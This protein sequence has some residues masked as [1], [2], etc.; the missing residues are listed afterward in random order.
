MY[1]RECWPFLFTQLISENLPR[2]QHNSSSAPISACWTHYQAHCNCILVNHQC[3]A[4]NIPAEPARKRS[5]PHWAAVTDHTSN[6]PWLSPEVGTMVKSCLLAHPQGSIALGLSCACQSFA[7]AG[8][9]KSCNKIK[10]VWRFLFSH[11][12]LAQK[13]KLSSH[14]ILSF[15]GIKS[16]WKLSWHNQTITKIE[17]KA[18]HM[19]NAKNYPVG[20]LHEKN[21]HWTTCRPGQPLDP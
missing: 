2:N 1:P 4:N 12:G 11:E 6:S 13:A 7:K 21:R 3:K 17:P 9:E 14:P 19:T 20:N 18:F 15:S 5:S 16:L 10:P 8:K